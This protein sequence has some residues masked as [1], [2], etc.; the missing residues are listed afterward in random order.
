[1]E[2]QYFVESDE[3]SSYKF[4]KEN[5]EKAVTEKT[6]AIILNTPN[7]PTGTIYNKEE[8]IEIAELAKKIM[9]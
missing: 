9:L 2:S 4:T 6:K 5:L 3:T 8:L 1:M 7:N